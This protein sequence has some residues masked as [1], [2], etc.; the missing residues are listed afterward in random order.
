MTTMKKIL[1]DPRPGEGG[2]A[3]TQSS[4]PEPIPA[5]PPAPPPAADT[6]LQGTRS[7]RELQLEEDLRKERESKKKLET[8]VAHLQDEN[9]RLKQVPAPPAPPQPAEPE[10]DGTWRVFDV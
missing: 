5:P 7:E 1:L 4:P 2:G 9:H 3:A 6:V 8:D 10:D